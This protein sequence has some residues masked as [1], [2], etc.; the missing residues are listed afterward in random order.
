MRGSGGRLCA[1]AQPSWG[2][3]K[4]ALQKRQVGQQRVGSSVLARLKLGA[5]KAR[6]QNPGDSNVSS[7][8]FSASCVHVGMGREWVESVNL[9]E[10]V[11]QTLGFCRWPPVSPPVGT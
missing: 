7:L 10:L 8:V 5:A 1:S 4:E 9:R 2:D 3:R 11:A 6:W